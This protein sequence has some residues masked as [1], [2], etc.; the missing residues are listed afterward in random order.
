MRLYLTNVVNVREFST[1]WWLLMV[2]YV[3]L[4]GDTLFDSPLVI[5]SK[6]EL[7]PKLEDSFVSI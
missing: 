5:V 7:C 4:I 6:S 3:Y 2:S 1:L